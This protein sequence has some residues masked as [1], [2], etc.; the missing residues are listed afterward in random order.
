MDCNKIPGD[1]HSLHKSLEQALSNKGISS[2]FTLS[3]FILDHCTPAEAALQ[4]SSQ[5]ELS[6]VTF[7]CCWKL[8]S[9]PKLS[10]TSSCKC[11]AP[12]LVS[13]G[14]LNECTDGMPTWNHHGKF[15]HLKSAVRKWFKGRLN[16]NQ[17]SGGLPNDLGTHQSPHHRSS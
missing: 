14:S 1:R 6:G 13:C 5:G 9:P 10:R 15:W 4:Q 3:G 17:N 8:S 7:Q 12:D 2:W 11:C 16:Q